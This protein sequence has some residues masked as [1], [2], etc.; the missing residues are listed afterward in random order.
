[1]PDRRRVGP[2][3]DRSELFGDKGHGFR[4]QGRACSRQ[5][6]RE[7]GIALGGDD[8]QLRQEAHITEAFVKEASGGSAFGSGDE[9]DPFK[10]PQRDGV[11]LP[12]GGARREDEDQGLRSQ[13]GGLERGGN[14]DGIGEAEF[15]LPVSTRSKR[16]RLLSGAARSTRTPGW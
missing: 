4:D 13:G 16:S 8:S 15:A 3:N 7:N 14:V 12:D 10:V 1:M 6:E 5:H 2:G 9:G 11:R